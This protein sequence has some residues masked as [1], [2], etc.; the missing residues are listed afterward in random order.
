MA[1]QY[2]AGLNWKA[3]GEKLKKH[4]GLL[5][6]ADLARADHNVASLAG[7]IQDRTGRDRNEIQRFLANAVE[8]CTS[9]FDRISEIAR[10]AIADVGTACADMIR[11]ATE[12]VFRQAHNNPYEAV[13]GAFGVGVLLG[14]LV[15]VLMHHSE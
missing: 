7:I 3:L 11:P 2:V 13:C 12:T 9:E 15:G 1:S 6:D 14:A 10:K 5:T 8:E 4:W